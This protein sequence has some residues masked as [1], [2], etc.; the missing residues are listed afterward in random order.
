MLTIVRN[1]PNPQFPRGR[2]HWFDGDGM[3]H[4]VHL[5]NGQTVTICAD[6]GMEAGQEAGSAGRV[7]VTP[8]LDNPTVHLRTPPIQPWCGTQGVFWHG[9]E[10]S[11]MQSRCLDWRLLDPTPGNQL[12]LP[13][14][15]PK[16]MP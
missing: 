1:G 6:T 10:V 3:L 16:W 12:K 13:L 2:Y 11:H 5:G 8:Q 7:Y 9:K 4:G 15:I 14:P